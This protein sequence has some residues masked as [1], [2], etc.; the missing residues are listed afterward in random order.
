MRIPIIAS[1]QDYYEAKYESKARMAIYAL[2]PRSVLLD[3]LRRTLI[4]IRSCARFNTSERY[5]GLDKTE[6]DH[7]MGEYWAVEKYAPIERDYLIQ[8]LNSSY[9]QLESD[10]DIV[11]DIKRLMKYHNP[12]HPWANSPHRFHNATESPTCKTA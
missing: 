2:L 9:D 6:F 11:K 3:Q 10:E 12:F 8:L 4:A 1:I 5:G 7:S